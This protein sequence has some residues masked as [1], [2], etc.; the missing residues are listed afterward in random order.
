MVAS[1]TEGEDKPLKYPLMYAVCE[2]LVLN[3]IDIAAAVEF[4]REL[5]LQNCRSVNPGLTVIEL[6]ARTGEGIP[7]WLDWLTRKLPA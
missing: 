5:F 6:S 3:K 4:D 1:V 7:T 2:A